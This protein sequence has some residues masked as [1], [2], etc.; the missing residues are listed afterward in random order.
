MKKECR[1]VALVKVVLS[2][3]SNQNRG[4]AWV[5]VKLIWT[6]LNMFGLVGS[7][8][9]EQVFLSSD[10]ALRTIEHAMISS[11]SIVMGTID[12]VFLSSGNAIKTIGGRYDVTQFHYMNNKTSHGDTMRT[13]GDAMTSSNSIVMQ[14]R[15]RGLLCKVGAKWRSYY[16][17]SRSNLGK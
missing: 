17:V 1:S 4:R 12:Q 15:G 13:I 9:I 14:I 5:S 3:P 8:T 7:R 10:D 2:R 16:L 6:C 11:T